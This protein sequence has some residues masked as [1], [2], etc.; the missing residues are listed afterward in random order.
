MPSTR[1]GCWRA[2]P[3][4][5]R[6]LRLARAARTTRASRSSTPSMRPSRDRRERQRRSSC[7]RPL[8]RMPSSSRSTAGLSTVC[9]ITEG[10]PVHDM[11]RVSGY[12]KG[13][14]ATLIGPNCPAS[15]RPRTNVSIMP[16]DIFMRGN[17]G[18][19]S[20]SGTLHIPDRQRAHAAGDRAEHRR[21]HRGRP[22][23]RDGLYRDPE[24]VEADPETECAVMIGEIGGN[25]E[26]LA[27]EYVHERDEH[28]GRRLHR[29]LHRPRGQD[30]GPR[31][32]HRLGRREHGRGQERGPEGGRYQG[33]DEPV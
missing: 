27:A 20:R 15:S 7:P 19:V 24:P 9:R 21:R 25:A 8:P 4:W 31:M 1:E 32:R 12:I 18:V 29:G 14:D 16:G 10:I 17:V 22:H 33:G 6:A 30:D 28:P 3:A 13:K 26:Q 2:A 11:M 23:H 5:S